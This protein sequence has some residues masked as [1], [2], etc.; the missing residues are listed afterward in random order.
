MEFLDYTKKLNKLATE[1]Q[2]D[3]EIISDEDII[4]AIYYL[5]NMYIGNTGDCLIFLSA[6]N[7]C[8][9]YVKNNKD[10]ISYTFKKGIG[11]ILEVLNYRDIN[12]I[13]INCCNDKGKLYIFQ[14]G[15]IQFSF[16]DEKNVVIRD[17]YLK[18]LSWDGV[19]KQK[20]AKVVFESA[21][22]NRIRVTNMTYRG[23]IL[24]EKVME[25]LNNY[26]NCK[27]KFDD[28]TRFQL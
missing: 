9:A 19:R 7:L 25:M 17:K 6:L 1:L 5:N 4:K 8:N 23:R 12:D 20:C 10:K 22:N 28:L 15:D 18:E 2:D 16:H 27:I 11:Y 21:I 3:N 24:D 26:R 13:Y 14:I